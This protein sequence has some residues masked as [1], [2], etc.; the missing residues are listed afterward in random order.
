MN[1]KIIV[2]I[3]LVVALGTGGTLMAMSGK[4]AVSVAAQQKTHCLPQI[5]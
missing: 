1:K 3:L 2:Y 4:D 5:P